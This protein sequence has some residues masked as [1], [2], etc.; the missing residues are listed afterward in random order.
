MA[1]QSGI[2]SQTSKVLP[3]RILILGGGFA[4]ISTARR[5]ERLL[6]LREAH[7]TVVSRENFSLFTPMLPEV[8]SGNLESRHVVTPVRAQLR[9][10]RFILGEVCAIDLDA[11]SV[12]IEH[13]ML[14][15]R[16]SLAYDHLVLCLGAVTS[17]FGLPGIAERAFPLK[18]LEDAER[19][20]NHVI[21]MLELADV[22]EDAIERKR[23]LTFVFVGG[24]FT[25]VEAAGEMIDFFKSALRFYRTIDPR[26]IEIV[27]IDGGKKL[28]P[29]LQAGMGEYSAKALE[30]RGV[31]VMLGTHVSGAFDD[32]L[33]LADGTIVATATIVWSAGVKPSPAVGSSPIATGRGGAI[34]VN[35]DLSVPNYPGVWALGDCATI[36]APNGSRYPPTAQHALREGPFLAENIAAVLRGRPTKPFRYQSLGVMASLG[37]RRG[38]AG[39][40]GGLLLT[41]FVAWFVWRTYYLLRLPGLDRQARVAF[42]WTLGLIFPRDISELRVYTERAQA[43]SLGEAGIIASTKPGLPLEPMPTPS[44]NVPQVAAH[45]PSARRS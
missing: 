22:T 42:D 15:S 28:L 4:G 8:S 6:S 43:N 11:K 13:I 36:P 3:A 16:Q 45:V 10:A 32:G 23:L 2:A 19:L 24:G 1:S 5:L 20:R 7:I 40:R 41:G 29:E 17:T 39:F 30:R 33:H 26:E 14:G 44:T 31:R 9:N 37:G 34:P 21:G 18:S 38:V 27:L 25:G 12:E 35:A